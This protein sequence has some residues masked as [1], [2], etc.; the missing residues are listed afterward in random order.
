MNGWGLSRLHLKKVLTTPKVQVYRLLST[1]L[2]AIDSVEKKKA[3]ASIERLL[4]K[5]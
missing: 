2:S 4:V 3:D 1:P 5:R